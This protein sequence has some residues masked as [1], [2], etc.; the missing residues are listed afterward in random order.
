M[1]VWADRAEQASE[2]DRAYFDAHPDETVYYREAIPGES[3]TGSEQNT[4][5]IRRTAS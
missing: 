4:S 3:P 5:L 1:S 2:V